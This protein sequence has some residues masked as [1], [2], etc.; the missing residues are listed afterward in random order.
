MDR[1]AAPED[2]PGADPDDL[3]RIYW[4][5]HASRNQPEHVATA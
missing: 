2:V 1:P 5:L 3:A 4:D